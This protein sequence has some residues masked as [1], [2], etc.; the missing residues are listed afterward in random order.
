MRLAR[1]VAIVWNV[2]THDAGAG[3]KTMHQWTR[4]PRWLGPVG[5][6]EIAESNIGGQAPVPVTMYPN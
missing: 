3:H 2:P 4:R 6:L 5:L 1:A